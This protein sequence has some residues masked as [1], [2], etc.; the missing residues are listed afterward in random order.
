VQARHA[1]QWQFGRYVNDFNLSYSDPSIR[2]SRL[3]GTVT[4]YRSQARYTVADLGPA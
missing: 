4:A 2:Q 3:S 1:L